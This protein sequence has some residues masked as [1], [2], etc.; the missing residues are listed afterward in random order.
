MIIRAFEWDEKNENHISR[1]GVS[2]FEVEE[3]IVLSK[4]FYQ[5]GREGKYV[6]Y[7]VTQEGRHLLIVFVIVKESNHIRVITAREMTDKEKQYYRKHRG[8]RS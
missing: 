3:V 8:G 1:H 4:P 6:V 2:P 7:G 5:R